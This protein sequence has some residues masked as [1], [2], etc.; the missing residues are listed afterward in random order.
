MSSR[1]YR[2]E[3]QQ[4]KKQQNL[5]LGLLLGGGALLVIGAIAFAVINSSRV[6]L[7]ARQIQIPEYTQA[8]QFDVSSLGDPSAPVVIDV[9]SDFSCSHCADFAADTEKLLEE[10]YIKTGKAS[11]VYHTVGWGLEIPSVFQATESAFCAGEQGAFWQFHDLIFANQVSLFTS[12]SVDLSKTMDTF[13]GMLDLDIDAFHTCLAGDHFRDVF[14][15]D[16]AAVVDLGVTGT[17]TFFING[18]ELRGNQ[19]FANFQQVIEQ[20]LASVN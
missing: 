8:Q 13:A 9:Y 18:Q 3:R 11:L 4:K 14:T 5:I 6:N 17:P 15:A 20:A 10:Q 12:A 2:N 7:N 1:K 16:Q 19:P